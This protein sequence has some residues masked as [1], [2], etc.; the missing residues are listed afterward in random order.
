MER[1]LVE[2]RILNASV[3]LFG[4]NGFHGTTTREIARAAAVNEATIFRYFPRKADLSWAAL[5][6]G[7]NKLTP[8]RELAQVLM[9]GGALETMIRL[10]I[11]FFADAAERQPLVT[12]L[13]V[14]GTLELGNASERIQRRHLGP[15]L[16]MM[17]DYLA[18]AASAGQILPIDPL[19]ATVAIACSV[20]GYRSLF[21]IASTK[22]A[23]APTASELPGIQT[24]FWLQMLAKPATGADAP[25]EQDT[26]SGITA[27][28]A[29]GAA[30]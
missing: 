14:F 19:T 15:L 6:W 30:S 21:N 3:R 29:A 26:N 10:T 7:L 18:R 9:G 12:R 16:Q 23:V 22:D 13:L 27:E 25:P 20:L 17:S 1:N 8:P 2:S 24:R 11:E 4:R 28:R 5:Q